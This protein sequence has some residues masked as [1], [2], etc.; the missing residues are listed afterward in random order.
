MNIEG[1]ERVS[2]VAQP[3]THCSMN[4]IILDGH[5]GF[6]WIR[7]SRS[8]G[9]YRFLRWKLCH[10]HFRY[11]R[12]TKTDNDAPR[13]VRVAPNM[14][15]AEHFIGSPQTSAWSVKMLFARGLRHKTWPNFNYSIEYHTPPNSQNSNAEEGSTLLMAQKPLMVLMRN[16][17]LRFWREYI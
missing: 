5:M 4:E 8:S 6:S 12:K 11:F 15:K 14:S 2:T 9:R 1:S 17:I 13:C 7:D 10:T 3:D 16:F